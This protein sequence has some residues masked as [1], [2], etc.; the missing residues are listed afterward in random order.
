MPFRNRL[1]NHVLFAIRVAILGICAFTAISGRY[2]PASAQ[3]ARF[4]IQTVPVITTEDARQDDKLDSINKHLQA[5]D[6][7]VKALQ[8]LTAQVASDVAVKEGQISVLLGIVCL[9]AG[10][11]L[12]IQIKR[13]S[14]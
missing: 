4:E 5:T 7:N 10:G 12:V 13:K 1:R 2:P 6:D 9:L 8:V 3:K 14:V 11:G